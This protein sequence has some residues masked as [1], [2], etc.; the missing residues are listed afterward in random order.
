MGQVRRA[1]ALT[2]VTIMSVPAP[3]GAQYNTAELSGVVKDEK[4]GVLPGA[5]VVALHAAS[6]RR[7]ERL[8]GSEGR[9]TLPALPV[10]DYQVF[11]ELSGFKRFEQHGLTLNVGQK[12]DL[13]I[14][15]ELGQLSE[16]ISVTAEAPLL[17]TSN[18]EIAEIIDNRQMQALPVNGRQFIHL[19]QLTDGVS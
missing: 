1:L 10:G 12:V 15:L 19:A 7:S 11:V 4:G 2:I 5:N 13:V 16:A 9:F 17:R 14:V 3:A 6:G 8:S 18:P